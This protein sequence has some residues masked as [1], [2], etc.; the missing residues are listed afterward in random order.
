MAL[1][2]AS[3]QE[4]L[5][6]LQTLPG[7]GP[8]VAACIALFSLDKAEAIPVDTHVWQLAV[9]YYC[10]H[11]ADKTLTPRIHGEVQQAFQEVFG[12]HC[13]W[14]HNAL[15]I[16][17]LAS[18]R[19][20]LPEHLQPPPPP[21]TPPK[22][23]KKGLAGQATKAAKAVNAAKAATP[24]KKV[25]GAKKKR[26]G[27]AV[28][29]AVTPQSAKRKTKVD[30]SP[31]AAPTKSRPRPAGE[32]ATFFSKSKDPGMRLLSN[33]AAVR[34][35][36]HGRDYATGEHAFHGEKYRAA[37]EASLRRGD[38]QRHQQLCQYAERFLEG[39]ADG[40]DS[41]AAAKAG[42]GGRGMRLEDAELEC[43]NGGASQ[44]VM[45]AICR[46]KALRRHSAAAK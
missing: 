10:P 17:E 31:P 25:T 6:E 3:Y 33:S 21:P 27:D 38:R 19:A 28:L 20:R 45:E 41:P 40:F 29:V 26:D 11:L 34:V 16:S 9:R 2:K 1:R 46:A 44:E 8:K 36:I 18:V 43:W 13:G 4:A 23:E 12:E 15:F 35:C 24:G 22:A 42:G 5:T 30:R 37:A 32:F 14:A 7:V 39:A